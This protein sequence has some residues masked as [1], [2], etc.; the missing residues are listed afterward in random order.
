MFIYL[1]SRQARSRKAQAAL[2]SSL[3]RSV[4]EMKV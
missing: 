4:E 1:Q 3:E 2:A